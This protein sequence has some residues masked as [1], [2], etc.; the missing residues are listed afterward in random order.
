LRIGEG[1]VVFGS[2]DHG[3][4]V[5]LTGER[6]TVLIADLALGFLAGSRRVG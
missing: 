4:F 5:L 2:G 3:G 6:T 1:E